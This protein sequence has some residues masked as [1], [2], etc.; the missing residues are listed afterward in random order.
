[1]P[2]AAVDA[3]DLVAVHV[4]EGFTIEFRT[5]PTGDPS[6]V[7]HGRRY[8]KAWKTLPKFA[9][10][11]SPDDTVELLQRRGD[12]PLLHPH[13]WA[14]TRDDPAEPLHYFRDTVSLCGA[15][16]GYG[17]L[18]YPHIVPDFFPVSPILCAA[19]SATEGQVVSS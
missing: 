7:Q 5:P 6:V 3:D 8:L 1:M 12:R 13:G 18:C 4:S 10:V 2:L 16:V 9:A 19:C 15:V 11:A 17:G 14:I